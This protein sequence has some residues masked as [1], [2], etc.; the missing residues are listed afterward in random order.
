[1][2]LVDRALSELPEFLPA[3]VR[4]DRAY[5]RIES[6]LAHPFLVFRRVAIHSA[7]GG[8]TVHLTIH[9]NSGSGTLRPLF[10]IKF[11][12]YGNSPD[13]DALMYNLVGSGPVGSS[14]WATYDYSYNA[15]S[16]AQRLAEEIRADELRQRER[17]NVLLGRVPETPPAESLVE[18]RTRDQERGFD[19]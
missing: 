19:L 18:Q 15:A 12:G 17:R 16:V 14:V 2:S 4:R 5:Q 11:H 7:S 13:G 10:K 8:S 6:E 9:L 1:M 3:D